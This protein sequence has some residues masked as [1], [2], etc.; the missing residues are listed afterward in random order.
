VE[1]TTPRVCPAQR[2]RSLKLP[3]AFTRIAQNQ[4][5]HCARQAGV[6]LTLLPALCRPSSVDW[7]PSTARLTPLALHKE[8]SH[9]AMAPSR[10]G[11]DA[12]LFVDYIAPSSYRPAL[13]T[14]VD[15][16]C[17]AQSARL[18]TGQS[19]SLC[20]R[21]VDIVPRHPADL[22]PRDLSGLLIS[23]RNVTSVS[24]L[25]LPARAYCGYS[26]SSMQGPNARHLARLFRL[27]H[28]KS[29][30]RTPARLGLTLRCSYQRANSSDPLS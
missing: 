17:F 14:R 6:D 26:A 9:W 27:T 1:L 12:V 11:L 23:F 5:G 19:K 2:D 3:E 7:N 25:A 8:L 13:N 22:D 29:P 28:R 24:G 20:G 21:A 15:H 30:S 10:L 18:I 16:R 4:P